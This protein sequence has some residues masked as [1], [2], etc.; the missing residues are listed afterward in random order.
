MK[1]GKLH[2]SK[3]RDQL[4]WNADYHMYRQRITN[5]TT[6]DLQFFLGGFYARRTCTPRFSEWSSDKAKFEDQKRKP[7]PETYE[8]DKKKTLT[9]VTSQQVSVSVLKLNTSCG[10]FL[11]L[12][13]SRNGNQ[14]VGFGLFFTRN[15][16]HW[17]DLL[18]HST[19]LSH[20][21]S[22]LLRCWLLW[23]TT[24]PNASVIRSLRC[25][26]SSGFD[27][28]ELP[29]GLVEPLSGEM[30]M[31]EVWKKVERGEDFDVLKLGIKTGDGW[32]D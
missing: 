20:Q 13:T 17:R 27:K 31:S 12:Q 4:E 29:T 18:G 32:N 22:H 8:T 6:K 15:P 10:I 7:D 9:R 16:F 28:A 19:S 24:S 3:S 2:R 21:L 26:R 1:M 14:W 23:K 25:T 5:T 11:S 30:T